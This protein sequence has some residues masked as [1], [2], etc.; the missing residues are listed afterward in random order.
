MKLDAKW[1]DRLGE[2]GERDRVGGDSLP[3]APEAHCTAWPTARHAQVVG[4]PTL[5]PSRQ[6][7]EL[8]PHGLAGPSFATIS[9]L[10]SEPSRAA[11]Q[12]AFLGPRSRSTRRKGPAGDKNSDISEDETVVPQGWAL[13][14]PKPDPVL[15][16]NLTWTPKSCLALSK[17]VQHT[18]SGSSPLK[19]G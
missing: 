13:R 5:L 11:S 10:P 7:R 2:K 12:A 17:S 19:R 18:A 16:L 9:A 1:Q 15:V 3:S 4:F 6:Q 8:S 14:A